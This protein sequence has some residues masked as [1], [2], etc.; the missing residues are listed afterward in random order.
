MRPAWTAKGVQ[1]N[2]EDRV[3]PCLKNKRKRKKNYPKITTSI[4]K[5]YDKK[6]RIKPPIVS[7]N[8]NNNYNCTNFLF[9]LYN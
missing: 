1:D 8:N 4:L 2:L 6:E 3:R 7:Q 9:E 5:I